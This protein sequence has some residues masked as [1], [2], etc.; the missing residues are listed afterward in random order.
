MFIFFQ[1]FRLSAFCFSVLLSLSI[2]KACK[3]REKRFCMISRFVQVSIECYEW[4]NRNRRVRKYMN[5]TLPDSLLIELENKNEGLILGASTTCRTSELE[6]GVPTGA[7]VGAL[8]TIAANCAPCSVLGHS[9]WRFLCTSRQV[10]QEE[11]M[12]FSIPVDAGGVFSASSSW[13][14]DGFLPLK[15][16]LLHFRRRSACRRAARSASLRP[17]SPSASPSP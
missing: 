7:V 13:F 6:V 17:S 11:T 5:E 15:D 10:L 3:E 14:S 9:D 2:C 4:R 16:P 8:V 1:F 12:S